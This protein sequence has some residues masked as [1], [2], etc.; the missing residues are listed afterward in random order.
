VA[1][2][3]CGSVLGLA[4]NACGYVLGQAAGIK[5]VARA[6]WQLAKRFKAR[7]LAACGV[8]VAAG[9]VTFWAGPWLGV[10]AAWVAGFFGTLAVQARN[11]LRNLFAP[12]FA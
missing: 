9:A 1:A 4:P 2:H 7:L 3:A 5:P 10:A 8:G 12:A 6:G 11:A